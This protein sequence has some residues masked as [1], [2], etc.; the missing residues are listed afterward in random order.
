MLSNGTRSSLILGIQFVPVFGRD[1]CP[2]KTHVPA[3]RTTD[4][5]S[6]SS[7]DQG[8]KNQS[9]S[10]IPSNIY[11]SSLLHTET[12]RL[13]SPVHCCQPRNTYHQRDQRSPGDFSQYSKSHSV[14][15]NPPRSIL[16]ALK[17]SGPFHEQI[18][19]RHTE[20]SRLSRINTFNRE[21]AASKVPLSSIRD[22]CKRTAR[23]PAI[24]R[25]PR[26]ALERRPRN[27]LGSA[28]GGLSGAE[29]R[30]GRVEP[31]GRKRRRIKRGGKKG[32][33][34]GVGRMKEGKKNEREKEELGSVGQNGT[35]KKRTWLDH[36]P[37]RGVR[38]CSTWPRD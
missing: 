17:H 1:F 3:L 13:S 25:G 38:S 24:S 11:S 35:K 36:R 27:P 12:T 4:S 32:R 8:P 21:L 9:G 5:T 37:A 2:Q 33:G 23:V 26:D 18:H 34:R 16:S 30:G 14:S 22:R 31:R 28:L 7:I 19:T 15:K 29:K 20:S 10:S 6:A